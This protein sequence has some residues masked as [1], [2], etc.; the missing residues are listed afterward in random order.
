MSSDHR[1]Q[2]CEGCRFWQR[3][4]KDN[5]GVTMDG[6]CKRFPPT[7]VSIIQSGTQVIMDHGIAQNVPA[8]GSSVRAIWATMKKDERACG[9]FKNAE[10]S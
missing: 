6:L 3:N 4:P 8:L 7:I 1:I 5:N 9:E 2:F 10:D